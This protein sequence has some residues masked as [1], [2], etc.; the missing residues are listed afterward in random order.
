M[1][2]I[3]EMHNIKIRQRKKT[4]KKNILANNFDIEDKTN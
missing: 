4:K 2:K 1:Y 3:L